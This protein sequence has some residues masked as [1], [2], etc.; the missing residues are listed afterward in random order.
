MEM[1]EQSKQAIPPKE[2]PKLDKK[3]VASVK[4]PKKSLLGFLFGLLLTVAMGGL[5][6]LFMKQGVTIEILSAQQNKFSQ[7]ARINADAMN[8]AQNSL[9]ILQQEVSKS[10]DFI[11]EQ[12]LELER[13]NRE[14]IS[15]RLKI[16]AGGTGGSQAW[17]LEEAESLLRI[18]QQRLVIS[19]D[20]RSALALFVS[21]DEILKQISDPAIFT[22]RNILASDVAALRS[23]VEIDVQG[24]YLQLGVLAKNIGA[25][26]VVS[27]SAEQLASSEEIHLNKIDNENDSGFFDAVLAK[28]G[29]YVVVRRSD[30]AIQPLLTIEQEFYIKQNIQLQLEQARLALLRGQEDIYRNSIESALSNID[31]YL[32]EDARKKQ[33]LV[34]ALTLLHGNEIVVQLPLVTNTLAALQ[35][36]LPEVE[37]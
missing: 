31:V 6:Y 23:V 35:Q 24:V 18:A 14:L 32:E 19:R 22:I 34:E 37:Q 20:V 33:S 5:G 10:N 21:A 9:Q 17:Q 29:E 11:V 12:K 13:L 2:L 7:Q 28:L 3:K 16:N 27:G 36:I 26:Q 1:T 8:A 4:Q 15:A 30:E 25:M